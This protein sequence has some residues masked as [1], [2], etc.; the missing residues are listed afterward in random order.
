[1]LIS[2]A[3]T[4]LLWYS[5]KFI[6]ITASVKSAENSVENLFIYYVN[7]WACINGTSHPAPKQ[8]Y[9][10]Y[11][12]HIIVEATEVELHELGGLLLLEQVMKISYL[13]L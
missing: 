5:R 2:L 10:L 3:S 11:Q 12:F 4:P 1:L 7:T 8:Q 6:S 9:H 13:L